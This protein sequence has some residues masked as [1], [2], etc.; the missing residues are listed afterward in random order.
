MYGI[1]CVVAFVPGFLH[2]A[3]FFFVFGFGFLNFVS[4]CIMY[5]EIQARVCR[6][7]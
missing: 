4:V 6:H 2:L 7:T 1:L 3:S 5:V